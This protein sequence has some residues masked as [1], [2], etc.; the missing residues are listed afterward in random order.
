MF[1]LNKRG[2]FTTRDIASFVFMNTVF[3]YSIIE[4]LL[5]NCV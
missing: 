4:F 5:I 1:F 3:K 2:Y